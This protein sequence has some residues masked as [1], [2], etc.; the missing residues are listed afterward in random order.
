MAGAKYC[1]LDPGRVEVL[2]RNFFSQ[3]GSAAES[4]LEYVQAQQVYIENVRKY[5][6]RE[7]GDGC[8][9]VIGRLQSPEQRD[10]QTLNQRMQTLENLTV[11]QL[12]ALKEAQQ[13]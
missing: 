8:Q 9:A 6:R 1:N 2:E 7:P 5:E 4:R 10:I 11:Q 3:L 12:E 13:N